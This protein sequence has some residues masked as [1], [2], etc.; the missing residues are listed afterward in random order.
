MKE[1][2]TS[3]P[4]FAD[5]SAALPRLTKPYKPSDVEHELR[6]PLASPRKSS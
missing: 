4:E 6:R 2:F 1:I 5:Q 3:G